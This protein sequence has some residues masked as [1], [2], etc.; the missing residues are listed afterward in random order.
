[1][2][3]SGLQKKELGNT[4]LKISELCLGLLPMGPLQLNVPEE[5]QI[6]I[7]QAALE[8]GVNF[9]D[10]AEAY[11]TQPTLGKALRGRRDRAVI[12]TKSYAK[13]Y[14][15]MCK[16]VE[17]S[18]RE[19]DTSY[20]DIYLMHNTSVEAV[21]KKDGA[22]SCLLKMKE[23]KVIR[24]IGVSLHDPVTMDKLSERDDLEVFLTVVNRD[25]LGIKNGTL[26][27]MLSAIA[28]AKIH[29]KGIYLMKT[30]AGGNRIDSIEDA[31]SYARSIPGV[32]S[33][34]VGI[35]NMNEL[36]MDLSFFGAENL[37]YDPAT[38]EVKSYL[39]AK[40]MCVGCGTC[41]KTCPGG[42]IEMVDGK[43]YIDR[44][45]CVRCGYCSAACPEFAI[46][47]V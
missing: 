47:F 9:F 26:A 23:E 7:I 30:L 20:I 46:R 33:L 31:F 2:T 14:D 37:S 1:M 8:H 15:E 21:E 18:L 10:T 3:K 44:E 43:A 39:V 40:R 38:K 45:K 42:I 16:A 22:L 13:T 5:E 6:E 41:V 25:G 36:M 34:A 28:K 19:L 35:V 32:A 24:A 27:D 12:T 17:K 4:G 29:G 11:Q